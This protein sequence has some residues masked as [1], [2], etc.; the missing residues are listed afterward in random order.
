MTY[1]VGE[2]VLVRSFDEFPTQ[3]TVLEYAV[4]N[5]LICKLKN[6]SGLTVDVAIFQNDILR[7]I[8]DL[9]TCNY[10][11]LIGGDRTLP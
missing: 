8:P 7:R 5:T 2:K 6:R 4:T 9:P 11:Q 1:Q 3:T 10:G